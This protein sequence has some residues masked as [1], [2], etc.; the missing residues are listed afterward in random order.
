MRLNP[1][2]KRELRVQGRG[3]GLLGLFC[4]VNILLFLCGILG[5]LAVVS[6][7]RRDFE[8][9]YGAMLC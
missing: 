8:A 9:D 6:R 4:A 5:S 1:I 2:L 7:M 3:Y